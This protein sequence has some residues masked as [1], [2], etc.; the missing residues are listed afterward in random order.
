MDN[1]LENAKEKY[2]ILEKRRLGILNCIDNKL[3]IY[4]YLHREKEEIAK[5]LMN[6]DKFI[7]SKSQKSKKLYSKERKSIRLS[8]VYKKDTSTSIVS[9]INKLC[10]S[11]SI[12]S[13]KQSQDNVIR[14][15]KKIIFNKYIRTS[16]KTFKEDIHLI[17]SY[18]HNLYPREEDIIV[19]DYDYSLQLCKDKKAYFSAKRKLTSEYLDNWLNE[20]KEINE[21]IIVLDNNKNKI[22]KILEKSNKVVKSKSI[23][24]KNE[25][26][27]KGNERIR[28]SLVNN[29]IN[30]RNSILKNMNET[31]KTTNYHK[32]PKLKKLMNQ[33]SECIE[34]NIINS[35][36]NQIAGNEIIKK[37]GSIFVFGE[38]GLNQYNHLTKSKFKK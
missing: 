6:S 2:D 13:Q 32:S 20:L 34:N 1:L 38:P 10:F 35:K 22:N 9:D 28:Q 36:F 14:N 24:N 5:E 8:K 15:D 31:T 29:S 19:N 33:I 26:I 4:E 11:N 12:K 17:S 25:S 23:I 3:N 21:N 37:R 7:S 16:I 30:N 27:V 18:N